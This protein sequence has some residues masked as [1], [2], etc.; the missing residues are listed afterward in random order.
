MEI[1]TFLIP[2][3]VFLGGVGVAAF[4]WALKTDQFSDPEGDAARILRDDD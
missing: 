2:I 3:S 1:L 4:V